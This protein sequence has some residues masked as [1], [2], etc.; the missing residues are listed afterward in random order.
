MRRGLFLK[1]A[2]LYLLLALLSFFVASSLGRQLAEDARTKSH[3]DDLYRLAQE[4]A[5]EESQGFFSGEEGLSAFKT[6]AHFLE[7]TANAEILLLDLSGTVLLDTAN[8]ENP[9]TPTLSD[10]NYASF[11]PGFYEVSDFFG[12]FDHRRLCVLLPILGGYRPQG[13]V[14]VTLPFSVIEAEREAV[15]WGID[16]VVAVNLILSMGLLLFFLIGFDRPMRELIRGARQFAAGNLGHRIEVHTK[17]EMGE[18]SS[19]L[20]RMAAE[21]KK[22][23]DYQAA[24]LSNVSHDLRSPLTS[25]KGFSEAMLDGTI[26]PEMHAHYLEVIAGEAERLEKLTRQ[27]LS[28]E[29]MQNGEA[30]LSLTDFDIN[31]LLRAT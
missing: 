4:I 31:A 29:K 25:I 27:L 13:Y 21:I 8:A 5:N 18:L 11:G 19:T 7:E 24:F 23:S 26:P 12:Y 17:D 20:N 6:I 3:A 22:S 30:T 10:F 28:L 16:V 2:G 1:F 9:E 15:M 14:A